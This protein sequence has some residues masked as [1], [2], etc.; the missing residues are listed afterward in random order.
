MSENPNT[1]SLK[2]KKSKTK[3]QKRKELKNTKIM[4]RPKVIFA[5]AF[6]FL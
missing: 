1:K 6:A 4:Q 5:Q 3:V 2:K